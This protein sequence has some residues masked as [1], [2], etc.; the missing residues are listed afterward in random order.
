MDGV[1]GARVSPK[2][3]GK[4]KRVSIE[5]E[6]PEGVDLQVFRR[7]AERQLARLSLLLALEALQRRTPTKG[8]AEELVR[9]V[10]RR[11]YRGTP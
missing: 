6:V 10:K 3:G 11:A 9:Q 7:E 2:V 5:V 1:A 4:V 8:E